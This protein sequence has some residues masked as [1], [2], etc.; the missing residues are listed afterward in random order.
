M[1]RYFEEGIIKATIFLR[2]HIGITIM[3]I[4]IDTA[5]LMAGFL[6]SM[7]GGFVSII[8]MAVFTYGLIDGISLGLVLEIPEEA[9]D[10]LNDRLRELR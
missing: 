3:L 8:G 4:L 5:I 10:R 1:K 7:V 2:K 9:I 6:L